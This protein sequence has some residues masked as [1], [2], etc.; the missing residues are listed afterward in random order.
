MNTA[1][2]ISSALAIL[3]E[4]LLPFSSTKLKKMLNLDSKSISWAAVA[5]Q[6]ALLEPKHLLGK[7]A[8]LFKQIEDAQMDA[9]REKL[10]A[11]SIEKN[12]E[13]K[14]LAPV[15][16]T[17][18][19]KDFDALDLRVAEIMQLTIRMGDEERTVVSGIATDFEEAELVGKKVTLLANL[20]PRSLRG[21]ESQGM[22]LLG[23]NQGGHLVF[24]GPEDQTTASGTPIK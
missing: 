10:S 19:F 4:P 2:Q 14:Q 23:E 17:T 7:T 22:I 16:P 8:L 15:K 20:K 18:S 3:A 6:K 11:A 24:V 9:Q 21:I 1:L 5:T 12:L 13:E